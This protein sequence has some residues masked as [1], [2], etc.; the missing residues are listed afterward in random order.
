MVLLNAPPWGLVSVNLTDNLLRGAYEVTPGEI[1]L[2]EA[3]GTIKA[4]IKLSSLTLSGSYE[5]TRG[6]ATSS[7]IKVALASMTSSSSSSSSDATTDRISQAK[8]R[9]QQLATTANGQLMLSTY[10][11]YNDNYADCFSKS[12]TFLSLWQSYVAPGSSS[13]KNTE[14]FAGVTADAD[15]SGGPVNDEDYNIHAFSM[16]NFLMTAAFTLNYND[17]AEATVNFKA[18]AQPNSATGQTVSDVMNVVSTGTPT[19]SSLATASAVVGAEGQHEHEDDYSWVPADRRAAV[20]EQVERNKREIRNECE[21]VRRGIINLE[22]TKAQIHGNYVSRFAS[23]MLTLTG[24]LS[25]PC[26]GGEPTVEFESLEGDIS[27]FDIRLGAFPG[28]LHPEVQGA[29]DKARFLHA[30]LGKRFIHALNRSPLKADI[31]RMLT[32]ALQGS[33]GPSN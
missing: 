23:P 4:Q 22:D 12:A 5:V 13:D 6:E 25:V 28:K 7:G 26:D 2:D 15:Q 10:Y 9:Q 14:Y 3:T 16:Q 1:G 20:R 31:G 29:L 18:N 21:D 24:K 27:D 19:K 8:A 33:L 30:V 32:L 11:Q 17:A